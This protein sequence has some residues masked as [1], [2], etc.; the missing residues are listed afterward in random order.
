[1][2]AH[3]CVLNRF[4]FVWLFATLWTVALQAPL[5]M[6]FSRQEYWSEL[7]C[8]PPGDLPDPGIEPMSLISPAFAGR[9]FTTRG[10]WKAYI[11][12]VERCKDTEI[13]THTHTHTHTHYIPLHLPTLDLYL[14]NVKLKGFDSMVFNMYDWL[15]DKVLQILQCFLTAS[16]RAFFMIVGR[17][18]LAFKKGVLQ[19]LSH[20]YLFELKANV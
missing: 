1:M 7:P 6:G 16:L 5:S 10:T 2:C 8:S 15:I 13:H 14:C 12:K 20:K 4:S 18:G 9:F 17:Q 11:Y 19:N 3:T